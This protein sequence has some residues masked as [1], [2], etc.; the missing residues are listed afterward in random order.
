M[1]VLSLAGCSHL[2]AD[3]QGDSAEKAE[4]P[5]LRVRVAP[6][7]RRLMVERVAG[8]GRCEAL[9]GKTAALTAAVEG[10]V[11][12]ILVQQGATVKSGQP[13]VRLDTRAAEANLNEKVAT[14]DGFEASLRLLKALPRV[15]EQETRKLA[16]QQ[17][18]LALDKAQSTAEHLRPLRSR[19]E[20][21]AQQMYEAELAVQQA[22]LQVQTAENELTVLML[23]P[24]VEAV[25][26]AKL[27]IRAAEA[28]V[29]SATVQLELHTLR[30]PVGGVLDRLTCQPGQTLAIG[31]AVGD[32]VDSRQVYAAIWLPVPDAARVQAG[33]P[34]TIATSGRGVVADQQPI[35]GKVAVVTRVADAQTGNLLVRAMIDNPQG[36]LVVGETLSAAIL[37]RQRPDAL[38]VPV[39]AVS[40]LGSG[41]I[42]NVVRDGKS[43]AL[44]PHLG[45]QDAGWI[46]LSDVELRPGEPVIVERG[47]NLPEG[48]E[49]SVESPA[50]EAPAAEQP[51]SKQSP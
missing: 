50:A 49:V 4:G 26:E 23:G 40:D 38:A 15:Q 33:Q 31:A 2:Q 27:R 20:I 37:L 30:A 18:K 8:L 46:E 9:P 29:A 22:R 51:R 48:T 44:H 17:A 28:A 6:A 14:R 19:N 35:T 34:V 32:I 42:V 12:E 24:R 7:Q 39:D 21:P 3:S 13:I 1:A 41:P 11:A 16:I 10:Q 25:D 45:I 47:Y 43:V 5:A 36:R